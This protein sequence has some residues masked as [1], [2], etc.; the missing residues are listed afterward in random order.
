MVDE[1]VVF[2]IPYISVVDNLSWDED[3]MGSGGGG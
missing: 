3:G 2:M 1:I